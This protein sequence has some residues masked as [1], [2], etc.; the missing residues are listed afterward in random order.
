MYKVITVLS[1]PE[2]TRTQQILSVFKN[3]RLLTGSY[4][5]GGP[6][7]R[8]GTYLTS[9]GVLSQTWQRGRTPA[10]PCLFVTGGGG[11]SHPPSPPHPCLHGFQA[12]PDFCSVLWLKCKAKQPT[13]LYISQPVP[14]D[15]CSLKHF[16]ARDTSLVCSVLLEGEKKKNEKR[17]KCKLFFPFQ[18]D[19]E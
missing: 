10:S 15:M 7:W 14:A 1:A 4:Q 19:S 18:Y 12:C 16:W 8:C 6:G 17:K 5:P 9:L 3:P 11:A 13:V 2:R